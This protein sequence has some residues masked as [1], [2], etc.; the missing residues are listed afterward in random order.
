MA[1]YEKNERQ[2]ASAPNSRVHSAGLGA[3]LPMIGMLLGRTSSS[4][5]SATVVRR[6]G[7]TPIGTRTH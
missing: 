2:E 1:R 6:G 4:R 7:S 5:V 3:L